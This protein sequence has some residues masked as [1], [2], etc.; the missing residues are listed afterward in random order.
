MPHGGCNILILLIET[1]FKLR[2]FIFIL[3]SLLGIKNAMMHVCKDGWR[4]GVLLLSCCNGT[5]GTVIGFRV[6]YVQCMI[7][8]TIPCSVTVS[9]DKV[10]IYRY[11]CEYLRA[12]RGVLGKLSWERIRSVLERRPIGPRVAFEL[13]HL[14]STDVRAEVSY[15][16]RNG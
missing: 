12:K 7:Y 10:K 5:A 9:Y 1:L 14:V 15:R 3:P 16:L 11:L 13:F 2:C 6:G 4:T 8:S